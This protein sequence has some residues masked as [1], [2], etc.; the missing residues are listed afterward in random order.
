MRNRSSGT[1][2]QRGFLD[3]LEAVIRGAEQFNFS[4]AE[5]ATVASCHA[6]QPLQ[7]SMTAPGF[8]CSLGDALRYMLHAYTEEGR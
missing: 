5:M 7:N 1:N 3:D 6:A 2:N 8:V 4:F